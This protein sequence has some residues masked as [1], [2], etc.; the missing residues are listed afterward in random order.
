MLIWVKKKERM[1]IPCRKKIQK[2]LHNSYQG[3]SASWLGLPHYSCLEW[4]LPCL[5]QS[6]IAS[7]WHTTCWLHQNC[8]R[9]HWQHRRSWLEGHR[10][11]CCSWRNRQGSQL[12]KE[13]IS[14]LNWNEFNSFQHVLCEHTHSYQHTHTHRHRHTHTYTSAH[15]EKSNY[16]FLNWWRFQ[17]AKQ[18][19][20]INM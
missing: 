4:S 18:I 16:E 3:Q 17:F 14:C 1:K 15:K 20:A 13:N 6:C 12:H 10:Q 9:S 8:H 19:T 11:S 5:L 2:K 7:S